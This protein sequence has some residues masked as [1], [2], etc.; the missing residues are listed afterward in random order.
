MKTNNE[1]D[2][3]SAVRAMIIDMDGVLWRGP[4]PIG[5]LAVVFNK[6]KHKG[7]RQS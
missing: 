4:E 5:D 2:Q 1:I 7:L 3:S 6:I